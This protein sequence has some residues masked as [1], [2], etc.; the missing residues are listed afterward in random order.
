M[1]SEVN[2]ISLDC[3]WKERWPDIAIQVSFFLLLVYLILERIFY[4]EQ[5][6]RRYQ[7]V[8]GKGRE[9]EN[10]SKNDLGWPSLI[11]TSFSRLL[12]KVN[13]N[14][15]RSL[16]NLFS[17]VLIIIMYDCYKKMISLL[18]KRMSKSSSSSSSFLCLPLNLFIFWLLSVSRL[19]LLE[20]SY[21]SKIL[22]PVWSERWS[23]VESYYKV[24][25]KPLYYY[26]MYW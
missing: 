26:P 20:L 23:W 6:N 13:L 12:A 8:T 21:L 10:P 14:Q 2:C 25:K 7:H 3:D 1:P 19:V 22:I 15:W 18:L 5:L 16:L 11:L 17:F 9:D 4:F 24:T